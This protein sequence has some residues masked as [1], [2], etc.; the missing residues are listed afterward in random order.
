MAPSEM[1]AAPSSQ[2]AAPF[3][4][5]TSLN[6]LRRT[7]VAR[8]IASGGTMPAAITAA[9]TFRVA[10]LEMSSPAVANR[11][12]DL[13][14]GPPRSKHIIRPRMTPSTITEAPVIPFSQFVNPDWMAAVGL[15]SR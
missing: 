5:S 1:N 2:A 8:A 3:S 14:T 9:M 11:Y 6:M 10:G 13:L 4:R 15:A 12:A 7:T